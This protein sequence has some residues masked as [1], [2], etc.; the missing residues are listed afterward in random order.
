MVSPP[1][2]A[3]RTMRFAFAARALALSQAM[4]SAAPVW[5][6]KATRILPPRLGRP[7]NREPKSMGA[8]NTRSGRAQTR[9]FFKDFGDCGVFMRPGTRLARCIR[10][11]PKDCQAMHVDIITIQPLSPCCLES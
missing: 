5:L 3:T 4:R 1:K 10:Q 7:E 8:T 11:T 6:A 9:G 2:G